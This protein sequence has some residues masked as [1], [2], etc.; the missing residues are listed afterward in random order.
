MRT[1]KI[2]GL[3][4]LCLVLGWMNVPA[5]TFSVTSTN[6]S[7]SVGT[8]RWAI[9]AAN[10][11][12]GLDTI[13]FDI[14]TTPPGSLATI[15]LTNG[16]PTIT[17]AVIID[18][19]TQTSN[20]CPPGIE[21]DGFN[22]FLSSGLILDATGCVVRGLIINRFPGQGIAI[23]HT[24][25]SC[26][27][28]G[29]YIG[30]DAS[31]SYARPNGLD[32]IYILNSA[33]N[34]IGGFDVTNCAERNII[35]GNGRNGILIYG[36]GSVSNTI[37]N[38]FIGTDVN[39]T[40]AV[41][42]QS[43]GICLMAGASMNDIGGRGSY[44]P[45][46]IISGNSGSGVMLTNSCN[47]NRILNNHIGVA[48]DGSTPLGNGKDGALIS[49]SSGNEVGDSSG[50]SRNIIAANGGDGVEINGSSSLGNVVRANFI[51]V[52]SNGF[53]AL[54]NNGNG[55]V[56]DQEASQNTIGGTT[57]P[58]DRNLISGNNGSGV[59]IGNG[60]FGNF[61]YGNYIG[62][63]Q[64]GVNAVSN[65]GHGILI[66]ADAHDNWIGNP[67]LTNSG[68]VISG[69]GITNW[70]NGITVLDGCD[71]T[72]IAGNL[73]G[74]GTNGVP[75]PNQGDGI[76][77]RMAVSNTIGGTAAIAR[78]V[79][80]AN[81]GDGIQLGSNTAHNVVEGNYIGTDP[82]G[83]Y[84]RGNA[85]E[86]ILIY[87]SE[88][89]DIG[90]TNPAMG[91]VISGNQGSGIKIS[92]SALCRSNRVI[93][94]YIG[95]DATGSTPL[96]NSD[97]GI[98]ILNSPANRIGMARTTNVIS[99]ND[100]NGILVEGS[101]AGGNE[102]VNCCVGTDLS[103][104]S[105]LG[106][107]LNGILIMN[108]ATNV[109]GRS[110]GR[111]NLISGNGLDG[112]QINGSNAC[113][114]I[115]EVNLIGTDTSGSG[116]ISN[117]RHGVLILA[118]ASGNVIGTNSP[119]YINRI[120]NN[121]GDGICIHSTA[122]TN[123]YIGWNVWKNNSGL[124]VDIGPDGVTSNDYQDP[125]TGANFLQNYP[126][127]YSAT[128]ASGVRV[129]GNLNTIPS[130]SN[131]V[132]FYL[133]AVPDPSGH[134][135]ADNLLVI[136]NLITDTNGNAAF[137]F[138]ISG[139]SYFGQYVSAIAIDP[140]GNS[141]EFSE[142]VKISP[143]EYWDDDGDGMPTA[144]ESSNHLDP[145]DATGTNGA[146]GDPDNDG[147]NNFDEYVADTDPGNSASYLHLVDI[148]V[149][150]GTNIF[151]EYTSTNTRYYLVQY[152]TNL[153]TTGEWNNVYLPAIQG[154]NG[155]TSDTHP[156]DWVPRRYR[157]KAELHR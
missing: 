82:S 5:A 8:L 34:Q 58:N 96:G 88:L 6:D 147:M 41:A 36:S 93:N 105:A 124:E 140:Y 66:Y 151:V 99:G 153:V 139:A 148:A 40:N 59:L 75:V 115:V 98:W 31:G 103:G 134:G 123:N 138:T 69:N 39:G 67:S 126:V 100:G 143:D 132:Y 53:S 19:T 81:K 68:N 49:F 97:H 136:T 104:N 42:N 16:L 92:N 80:S 22:T 114:N 133:C 135:G 17:N 144:W 119:V 33:N 142:A 137:D 1:W 21:L 83:M 65:R 12:P 130:T 30:T 87:N 122:G 109:V 72:I 111:G 131:T 27:I 45:I 94:C 128:T 7:S 46:N 62:V 60:A 3:T 129:N 86:G 149:V 57:Y 44:R 125:D 120:A 154:S 29:C 51:G 9:T 117:A 32:G 52:A 18:G 90:G 91:N 77:I 2:A 146:S 37:Y 11:F 121:G 10:S 38:N 73:I 50:E 89:N 112:I 26:R 102:I 35:S 63:N 110:G 54:P 79:I 13:R 56:I 145:Y 47:Y 78:N 28:E 61:I 157:V 118:D 20:S 84:A 14:N 64:S 25:G 4:G 116:A 23:Q 71:N 55:V 95:T 15:H 150:D 74:I 106:N 85:H 24:G 152:A 127:I 101:G 141:S 113:G 155:V 43:H 70:Y 76:Q 107:G 48:R 108:A 156:R